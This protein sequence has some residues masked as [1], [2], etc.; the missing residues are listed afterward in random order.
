[1]DPAVTS[2]LLNPWAQWGIVG[3]VV[4]ALATSVV[5]LISWVRQLV[6]K[7]TDRLERALEDK[8]QAYERLVESIRKRTK[9]DI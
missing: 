3:T 8:N 9:E 4:V 6:T 7:N 1:M 2:A 5:F